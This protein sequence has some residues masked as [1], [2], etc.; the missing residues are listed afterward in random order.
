MA[1]QDKQLLADIQSQID[2]INDC[3]QIM[4]NDRSTF[5]DSWEE[6]QR[7]RA[8]YY[9]RLESLDRKLRMLMEPTFT[10][11]SDYGDVMPLADFK[12]AC[13]DGMFIDSDG[14]GFYVR[15]GKES[16]IAVRPSD[17]QKKNAIRPDFDTIIWFNR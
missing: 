7:K 11:L 10:E 2:E 12:Q 8:P 9:K 6:H 15:D 4:D 14:M 5:D 16:D 13:E 17:F 1:S 3:I